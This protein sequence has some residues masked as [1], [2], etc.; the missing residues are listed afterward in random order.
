MKYIVLGYFPEK[1]EA[2]S[3]SER[4]AM[5][6]DCFTHATSCGKTGIGRAAKLFNPPTRR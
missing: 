6:D 4:N 3:E 1:F 5:F 2:M